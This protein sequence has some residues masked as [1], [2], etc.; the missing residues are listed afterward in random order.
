MQKTD[1]GRD[2]RL[3][4][5]GSQ[6]RQKAALAFPRGGDR[7]PHDRNAPP[8]HAQDLEVHESRDRVQGP[9]QR[10]KVR[11]RL[12][13]CLRNVFV[14][15]QKILV[16][17][18]NGDNLNLQMMNLGSIMDQVKG[19]SGVLYMKEYSAENSAASFKEN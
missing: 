4:S 1:R 2:R 12:R 19:K 5:C 11:I 8:A 10:S 18:G 16:E 15:Q 13:G 17:L 14:R 6:L 7:K 9:A 3:P